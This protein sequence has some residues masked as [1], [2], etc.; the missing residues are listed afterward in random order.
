MPCRNEGAPVDTK[1]QIYAAVAAAFVLLTLLP[2]P[3]ADAPTAIGQ[4]SGGVNIV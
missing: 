2:V 3:W 4:I 1:R